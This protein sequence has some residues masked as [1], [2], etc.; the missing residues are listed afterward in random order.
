MRQAEI[1]VLVGE[2]DACR[3]WLATVGSLEKLNPYVRAR[4]ELS[5]A[6]VE[7]ALGE[8]AGVPARVE[9][10]LAAWR[11]TGDV[12]FESGVLLACCGQREHGREL[13]RDAAEQFGRDYRDRVGDF[14]WY[15]LARLQ[16]AA[17]LTPPGRSG[18]FPLPWVGP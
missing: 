11:R 13:L 16:P 18:S 14:V 10:A 12:L 6:R 2:R 7:L 8:R 4:V 1:T 15:G 3:R 17:P 9:R 5:L